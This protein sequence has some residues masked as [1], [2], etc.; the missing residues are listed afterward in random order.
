MAKT[1]VSCL[2]GCQNN[3]II[4]FFNFGLHLGGGSGAGIV[5]NWTCG[6]LWRSK[7]CKLGVLGGGIDLL[8]FDDVQGTT[9]ILSTAGAGG[10]LSGSGP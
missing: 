10:D 5:P 8:F 2:K 4:C 9:Q 1:K 6:S 3:I 7:G